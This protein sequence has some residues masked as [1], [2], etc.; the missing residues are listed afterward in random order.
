MK[1]SVL[2]IGVGRLGAELG[3]KMQDLGNEVML[4][5]NKRDV[6]E[7]QSS[8]FNDARIADY[9]NEDVLRKLGCADFQLCFITIGDDFEAS[10]ITTFLLKKLGAAFVAARARDQLQC[11]ILRAAGADQIILSDESLAENLAICHSLDNVKNFM[12]LGDGYGIFE[13]PAPEGWFNKSLAE[14][15]VR[16]KF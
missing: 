14:L 10:V 2:I 7:K 13:T 15:D 4:L 3:E 5:D 12:S 9:T 1:K 16:R 11:D 8:R 6:I